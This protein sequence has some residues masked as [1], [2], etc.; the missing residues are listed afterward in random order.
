MGKGRGFL[1]E[2]CGGSLLTRS[3]SNRISAQDFEL[4]AN[5][6]GDVDPD[7]DPLERFTRM[8]SKLFDRIKSRGP[9]RLFLGSERFHSISVV[10][11]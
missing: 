8:E 4:F 10:L 1:G 7:P 5:V 11:L 2:R 9:L 3:E 6:H